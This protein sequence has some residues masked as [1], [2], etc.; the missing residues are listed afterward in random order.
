MNNNRKT[1]L[2][3]SIC[4]G[5]FV[6][7]LAHYSLTRFTV[8]NSAIHK[9]EK[10]LRYKESLAFDFLADVKQVNIPNDF[11]KYTSDI[12]T[13]SKYNIEIL[14][15][16]NDSLIFWTAPIPIGIDS[17]QIQKKEARFFERNGKVYE[18][19][20]K[21][22]N[23]LKVGINFKR[24]IAEKISSEYLETQIEEEIQINLEEVKNGFVASSYNLFDFIMNYNFA[25]KV[26]FEDRVT[27]YCQLI[28]QYE[29]IFEITDQFEEKQEIE[30]AMVYPK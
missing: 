12:A 19:I 11:I 8:S 20:K 5:A 27:I 2:Y 3:L 30:Y 15:T 17:L 24:P 6:I 29:D 7:M 23:R 9:I 21:I 10:S 28:S 25:K 1:I 16:K 14:F 22:A 4:V 26:S 18:S 13:L